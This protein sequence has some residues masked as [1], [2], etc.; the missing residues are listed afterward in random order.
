MQVDLYRTVVQESSY[1]FAY[2]GILADDQGAAHDMLF[3]EINSS[4]ASL[5]DKEESSIVGKRASEIFSDGSVDISNLIDSFQSKKRFVHHCPVNDRW[6]SIWVFQP[7]SDHVVLQVVEVTN[8]IRQSRL[9]DGIF[10]LSS[11]LLCAIDTEYRLRM[12]NDEWSRVLGYER[13]T[14]IGKNLF[15]FVHLGDREK[16]AQA[17]ARV[18]EDQEKKVCISR[19]R[20]A[21]GSFRS[22]EWHLHTN[23]DLVCAVGQDIT[24]RLAQEQAMRSEYDMLTLLFN[25]TL[26]GIFFMILD[27]PVAW[28]DAVDKEAVLDCIFSHQHITRANQAFFDLYHAT[29]EHIEGATPTE[30]FSHDPKQGRSMWRQ[31]FDAGR[32]H[33]ESETRRMDGTPLWVLGDYT[34]LYDNKNRIFG[35]FG[36]QLDISERKY[37]EMKLQKSEE[38]YRLI[39]EHTSDVIWVYDFDAK[40]FRYMSPSVE[41][42][43]GYDAEQ[44]IRLPLQKTIFPEDQKWVARTVYV[45]VEEFRQKKELHRIKPIEFRQV[46]R[47][48]SIVWVD[49][50]LN[51]RLTAAG[52]VELIGVNRNITER[53]AFEKKILCYS[54]HDQLTGLFNRHYYEEQVAAFCKKEHLPLTLIMCDL[55]GLKLTNDVFGHQT[56]D[57]LLKT[58]ADTLRETLK[59][60]D[61]IA[62]IGGDEFVIL[63]SNTSLESAQ[64]RIDEIQ[65]AVEEKRI[66]KARISVSFGYAV[67]SDTEEPIESL[68]K[69][70]EDLMYRHKLLESSS[71]KHDM[72][73]LLVGG[74]HEKGDFEQHHSESVAS[75]VVRIGKALGLPSEDLDEL[76]LAGLLHDIGKIGIDTEILNKRGPLNAH[77]WEQMRRHP[78]KGYQILKSV[79]NFGRIADWV[80]TH[81]ERPD[82]KGYPQGLSGTQ[83]PLQ[84]KIIAVANAY[85]SMTR[86]NS[87][88]KALRH[89]EAIKELQKNAG[90]QFDSQ[91][92]E[93][94]IHT[95]MDQAEH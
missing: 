78:E 21:D 90:T 84:A 82:G 52:T 63:L 7:D 43:L 46:H 42:L 65:R 17:I 73:K 8:D 93:A 58:F 37:N 94:F 44:I 9:Y 79:Q 4:F 62:R 1:G 50:S 54:Y 85:D 87:Y 68:Y 41:T 45:L 53:K 14:V 39:T 74:L 55:N 64:Q 22:V 11:V 60:K 76:R 15:A 48:G 70:A 10:N 49:V 67:M 28:N 20:H 83:I 19:M 12:V 18:K 86:I 81:H 3:L 57:L 29:R 6:Y 88:R 38:L 34:C 16:T 2:L 27:E 75:L 47:N 61:L 72:I 5:L 23:D 24:E 36:M 71:F 13:N 69:R 35:Y 25:Q 33:I 51:F 91:V 26:T 89:D 31:L 56:G 80:L 66:G 32:L 92:V 77:E 95:C 59:D 40:S 30:F